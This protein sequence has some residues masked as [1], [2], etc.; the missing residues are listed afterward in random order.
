[1]ATMHN[2]GIHYV[3][4]GHVALPTALYLQRFFEVSIEVRHVLAATLLP[5]SPWP[6]RTWFL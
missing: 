5:T 1:M 3:D 2:V 6:A 4:L